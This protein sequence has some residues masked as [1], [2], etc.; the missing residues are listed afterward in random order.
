MRALVKQEAGPGLVMRDVPTPEPGHGEVRVAIDKVS[1][2]G[3]DLHI[4]KWDKWAAATVPVPMIVGHEYVGRIDR[5]GPGVDGLE[6]GQRVSG[7]GHIVCGICRNCRAGREHLCRDTK[8][9]GVNRS[10][11]F[12]DFLVIPAHNAYPLP[13]TIPDDFASVLDPLGNAVHTALSFD[14]AGEDVLIT[15]AGPIGLMSTAICRHVGARHVVITDINDNRLAL[16]A[17]MGASRAVNPRHERLEGVMRDLGMKEGFDVGLE[18]SG[19]GA[20]L[21]SMIEVM[22]HG[23]RVGLLGIF[24]EPVAV[25]LNRAIF[26]GLQFKG[27]YGRE[28]FD[29]WHKAVSMLESGL[30]ISPVITHRLAFEDFSTGFEEALAGGASKVVLD[31]RQ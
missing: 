20:A 24:G 3:T 2:C 31:L 11:A 1:I 4:W 15:G 14:L 17:R 10:G 8:G 23:G 16:A 7:E 19:A 5:I 30:D 6:I 22:N 29:T 12:A 18:M 26:K 13:D 28:M 25:D 27:I 21:Q 9:V